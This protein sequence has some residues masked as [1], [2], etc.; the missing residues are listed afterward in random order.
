MGII[1]RLFFVTFSQVELSYF[2]GI[3][4]NKVNGQGIPLWAQL[5][6]QIFRL[7]H[8]SSYIQTSKTNISGGGHKLSEFAC[9]TE[10]QWG[11]SDL[12]FVQKKGLLILS[13]S[14]KYLEVELK[15]SIISV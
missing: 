1:L 12:P 11:I 4:Y 15:A 14:S 2:S 13:K 8:D 3:F 7:F 6:L 5:L 9:L 10:V